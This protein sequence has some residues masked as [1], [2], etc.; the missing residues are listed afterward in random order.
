VQ[1][2]AETHPESGWICTLPARPH[3]GHDDGAGHRWDNAEVQRQLAERR[4]AGATP[5]RRDRKPERADPATLARVQRIADGA[6]AS[7]GRQGAELGTVTSCPDRS[8]AP[9]S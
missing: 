1:T 5:R 4:T 9:P 7:M 3:L 6:R 2:C 8:D